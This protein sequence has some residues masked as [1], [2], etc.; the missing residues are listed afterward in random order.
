MINETLFQPGDNCMMKLNGEIS[1]V[2]QFVSTD[3]KEVFYILVK[4]YDSS[5]SNPRKKREES[6]TSIIY[7]L[8]KFV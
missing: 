4:I 2:G 5:C 6:T 1:I 8:G 3:A 7:D